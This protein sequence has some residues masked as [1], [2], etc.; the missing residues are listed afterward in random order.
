MRLSIV[1]LTCD[2]PGLLELTAL[3]LRHTD[4]P[5]DWQLDITLVDNSESKAGRA[6]ADTLLE[7]GI[8]QHLCRNSYNI[9][10]AAGLNVGYAAAMAEN[11]YQGLLRPDAVALVQDDVGLHSQWFI[12][13]LEALDTWPDLAVVSGYNSPLHPTLERRDSGRVKLYVQEALPGV[14][15]LARPAFWDRVFP[16]PLIAHHA[17]DD[18][19]LTKNAPGA[20]RHHGQVCGVV[21]GLVDHLGSGMSTWNKTVHP[22]YKDPVAEV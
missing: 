21:P 10:I 4:L 12:E 18:W 17:D 22:E 19:W 2:R 20:P 7:L 15:L 11:H 13:C 1:L 14:Q 6:E 16:M 3:A 8:V 9:G 5:V